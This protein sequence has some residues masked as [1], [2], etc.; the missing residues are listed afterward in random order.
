MVEQV[1]SFRAKLECHV[2]T[3]RRILHQREV[4][5]TE[6][7]PDHDIAA[8]VTEAWHRRENARV[9]PAIHAT[10]SLDR[11]IYI[12]AERVRQAV[13]RSIAGDDVHGVAGLNLHNR[14]QLPTS[15]NSIL[16]ER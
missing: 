14:S 4:D 2:L 9:E 1:E 12:R 15:D 7:W 3:Q 6:A 16:F 5:I 13:D 8:Q 11:T 10:D